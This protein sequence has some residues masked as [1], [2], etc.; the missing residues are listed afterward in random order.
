MNGM[1][2]KK[3]LRLVSH[4]FF[5]LTL[6]APDT[7]RFLQERSAE[8]AVISTWANPK[9]GGW[10]WEP[11]NQETR[12]QSREV[13][14]VLLVQRLYHPLGAVI[15]VSLGGP[16]G[17]Q[18]L[19]AFAGAT[20]GPGPSGGAGPLAGTSSQLP[21]PRRLQPSAPGLLRLAGYDTSPAHQGLRGIDSAC[22]LLLNILI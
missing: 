13:F 7:S 18:R 9:E 10:R 1:C 17:T 2:W 14:T 12:S 21:Q 4:S 3:H 5:P 6:Y 15:S 19:C 11:H 16:A 8:G 22:L 20:G